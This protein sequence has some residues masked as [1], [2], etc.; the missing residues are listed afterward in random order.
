M[1]MYILKE[2]LDFRI[3]DNEGQNP[4]ILTFTY[5]YNYNVYFA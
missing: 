2:L 5:V 4:I 1:F 3:M